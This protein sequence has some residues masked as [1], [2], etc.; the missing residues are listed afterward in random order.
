MRRLTKSLSPAELR[1]L[2]RLSDALVP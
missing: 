1:Q 2:T